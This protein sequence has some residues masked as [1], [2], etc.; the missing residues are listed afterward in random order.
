MLIWDESAY[1]DEVK[2]LCVVWGKQAGPEHPQDEG[3]GGGLQEE[4]DRSAASLHRRVLCRESGYLNE[5]LTWSSNTTALVKKA[6]QKDL[7][8][9]TFKKTSLP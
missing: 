1:W 6:Q 4:K 3:A 7:S 8:P 9:Q 5:D 2:R